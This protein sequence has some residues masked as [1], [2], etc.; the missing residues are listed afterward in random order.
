MALTFDDIGSDYNA[1]NRDHNPI[2]SYNLDDPQSEKQIHDWLLGEKNYLVE[3]WNEYNETSKRYHA[4][5]RGYQYETRETR[6]SL[7]DSDGTKA[8]AVKK[9]SVN[10]LYDL[11]E[12][13]VAR[14]VKYKPAVAVLPQSGE[15]QDKIASKVKKRVLD[16]IWYESSFENVIFPNACKAAKYLREAYLFIEWNKDKGKT[17]PDYKQNEKIPLIDEY[18]SQKVDDFGQPVFIDSV[19]RVGDVEYSIEFPLSIFPQVAPS[20]KETDYIIRKKKYPTA[21]L[22]LIYP[23]KASDIKSSDGHWYD[24]YKMEDVSLENET[25]VWEFVHKFNK[26]LPFGRRILFTD[27]II[28]E[29]TKLPYKHGKLPCVRIVDVD[30]PSEQRGESFIHFVKSLSGLYNNFTNMINRSLVMGAQFKWMMPAGAAKIESLG[31]DHTI[32]QYK[33]PV[34]PQLITFNPVSKDLFTFRDGIKQELQQISGVFGQSRGEPPTQVKSGIAIA[35]LNE[36]EDE[37]HNATIVQTNEFIKETAKMTLD[38]AAQY[39]DE[40]DQRVVKLMGKSQK[41]QVEALDTNHLQN[42]FDVVVQ[43]SSSLPQSKALRMQTIMEL[44]ERFPNLMPNEQIVELLDLGQEQEFYSATTAAVRAAEAENEYLLDGKDV[45]PPSEYEDLIIHWNV[46]SRML[47]EFSF[48]T[49][50]PKE[51][52]DKALEHMLVTEMMMDEKAM[53]SPAFAQALSALVNFPMVYE[54]APM[55]QPQAPMP[56]MDQMPLPPIEGQ[57]AQDFPMEPVATGM[58]PIEPVSDE[59]IA[60]IGQV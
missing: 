19:V 59:Q 34:A 30:V 44:S 43:N 8:S 10:H 38:V 27:N 45:L 21:L 26:G 53:K 28:L 24:Y 36:Q 2:W 1:L 52:Q 58:E 3:H 22:R 23:E 31:N 13:L 39:Y 5:Y 29:N 9:V 20:W 60:P 16:N 6:Q 51:I 14:Q 11:V 4:L 37:R 15:Y 48:K 7:R 50:T 17:H 42:E 54:R 49:T 25:I 47:Q 18:G 56:P 55:I 41:W 35:Y 12:N 40:T 33:G 46:H 32:V 57:P